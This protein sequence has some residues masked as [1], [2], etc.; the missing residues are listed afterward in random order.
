MNIKIKYKNTPVLCHFH[1]LLCLLCKDKAYCLLIKLFKQ[2]NPTNIIKKYYTENTPLY[3]ILI[4]HS[5]DVTNKA[6][7][8][9]EKHPELNIDTTFVKEAGMLHDIGIFMTNAPSI[10]C[11]GE[12]TYISHGYLGSELLE[13]EGYPKHALVCERHTGAGLMLNEII[14]QNIPIPHR[15]MM[16]ISIEEQ[17]ICFSDCFFSKTHLGEERS[18]EQVRKKLSKYGDRSIE[19]FGRWCKLFL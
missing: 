5:T 12:N 7:S 16:P 11:Y 14:E 15:E 9:A 13:K 3:N 4:N 2:M 1:Y 18:V 10:E 8:I 17:V 19:Q 6:L